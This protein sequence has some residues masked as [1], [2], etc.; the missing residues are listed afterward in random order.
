MLLIGAVEAMRLPDVFRGFDDEG[1]RLLVEL[2]DVG[3][4][5]AVL[6]LLEEK[7]ESVVELVRAEPDVAVRAIDDVGLEDG[8]VLAADA[9]VDAV[10]GND[11]IGIGILVGRRHFAVEDEFDA[12]D[13]AAR[14][15]DVEQLLAS[16]ADET[17]PAAA[18]RAP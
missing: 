7:G 16:D 9:R 1:R 18:D 14:L 12:E 6:G 17:V 11:Q 10:G 5:P 8:C 13:F 4:K 3:L 15:Q 2:V